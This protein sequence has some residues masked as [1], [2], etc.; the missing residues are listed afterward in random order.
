VG[1][2]DKA[3]VTMVKARATRPRWPLVV[4]L[5]AAFAVGPFRLL[6]QDRVVQVLGPLPLDQA[7]DQAR[8]FEFEVA[9]I[10]VNEKWKFSDPGYSLDSD[11]NF[12]PGE[13]LFIADAPLSTFIGFA[14]KL[15]LLHPMIANL[16]KWADEQSYE[17]RAR[18]P[19][20]PGKDQVRLMMR[21]L[22]IERF[23]LAIHFEKQ[24][25]PALALTLIKPGKLGPGL[26][27]HDEGAGCK[28]TGTSPKPEEKISSLD[29]LPCS[30]YLALDRPGG[31]IFSGARNT[32]MRQLCAFLSNVGGYGRPVIDE[33]GITGGIDFGM[34]STRPRADGVQQ[35]ESAIET[36]DEA[37]RYQLGVKLTQ[38]KALLDI[39]IVDRMSAPK[40]N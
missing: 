32:T 16:P 8:R 12:V 10:R 5:T 31:A 28:V 14:Y 26:H 6:G 25:K 23:Q 40:E 17:I 13:G 22:L 38:V 39:P 11:D 21:A 19:G 2:L 4:F 35:T 34:E 24:E 7:H 30:T 37:L 3:V 15:D 36:F 9:S 20:A 27:R 18:I 1:T 29:W 33:S